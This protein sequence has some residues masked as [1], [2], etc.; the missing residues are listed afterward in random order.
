MEDTNTISER[1]DEIG[2]RLDSL[3]QIVT[4]VLATRSV[5]HSHSPKDGRKPPSTPGRLLLLKDLY[6]A[7]GIMSKER[8]RELAQLHNLRRIGPFFR[9]HNASLSYVQGPQGEAVALTKHGY[10]RL[11]IANVIKEE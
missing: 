3:M 2:R 11:L 10:N 1:L 9:G 5:R 6:E 7:H 4:E 8:V